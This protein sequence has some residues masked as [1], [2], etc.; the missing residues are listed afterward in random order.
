[1]RPDRVTGPL[2]ASFLA[3]PICVSPLLVG[4]VWQGD[5]ARDLGGALM[6][7]FI[8]VF[9]G[10]VIALL[11]N[12]AGSGAMVWAGRHWR[13]ARHWSSWTSAGFA[14]AWML[15]FAFTHDPASGGN[16]WLGLVGASCALIC[17][18][19]TLWED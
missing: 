11:P 16:M 4:L 2:L 3:G 1:V 14:L 9:I 15:C 8:A 18:H 6:V 10:F 17:R 5:V 7:L 12:F 19:F 13:P